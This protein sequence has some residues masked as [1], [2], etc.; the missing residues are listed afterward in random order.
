VLV[1]FEDVECAETVVAVAESRK[2]A[3][4][5]QTPHRLGILFHQ[6]LLTQ[7]GQSCFEIE[8]WH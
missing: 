5:Q 7:P 4:M 8:H 6:G 3:R 2:L 1:I